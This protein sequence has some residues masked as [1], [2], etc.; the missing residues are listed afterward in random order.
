M[1]ARMLIWDTR[2]CWSEWGVGV[3]STSHP[4]C[5]QSNKTTG[6]EAKAH[7]ATQQRRRGGAEAGTASMLKADGGQLAVCKNLEPNT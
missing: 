2:L 3:V 7:G 1:V 4:L 6:P 5:T